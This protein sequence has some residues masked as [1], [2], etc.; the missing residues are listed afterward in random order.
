MWYCECEVQK[1]QQIDSVLFRNKVSSH[2]CRTKGTWDLKEGNNIFTQFVI[3][4]Y[5]F[6]EHFAAEQG[7]HSTTGTAGRTPESSDMTPLRWTDFEATAAGPIAAA[8]AVQSKDLRHQPHQRDQ[9]PACTWKVATTKLE[10]KLAP[11]APPFST[12]GG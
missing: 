2:S 4:H 3:E 6:S 5:C 9:G 7:C 12:R 10:P 11:R 1:A 8:G